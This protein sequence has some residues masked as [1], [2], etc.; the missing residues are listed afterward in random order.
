MRVYLLTRHRHFPMVSST[1]VAVSIQSQGTVRTKTYVDM[2]HALPDI[3]TT[4]T[5]TSFCSTLASEL[6]PGILFKVPDTLREQTCCD[7]V[8]ETRRDDEEDL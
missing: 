7:Q 6:N 1:V 5:G 2:P 4:R 8:E 3:V